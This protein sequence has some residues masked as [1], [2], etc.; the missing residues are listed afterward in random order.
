MIATFIFSFDY[1][2]ISEA[3]QSWQLTKYLG[4]LF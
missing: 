2:S 3:F 1:T 4:I